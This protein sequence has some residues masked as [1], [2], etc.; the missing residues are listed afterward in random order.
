[1]ASN[2]WHLLQQSPANGP[3][4][5][6]PRF[7]HL[8][9]VFG[10]RWVDGKQNGALVELF[11]SQNKMEE[12]VAFWGADR[13]PRVLIASSLNGRLFIEF[14]DNGVKGEYCH[15]QPNVLPEIRWGHTVWTNGAVGTVW[16]KF[17]V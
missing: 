7:A 10:G 17:T 2:T 8:C 9:H 16:T 1:M 14:K 4:D 13:R 15:P 3:R 6:C 11:Q 12:F 5:E